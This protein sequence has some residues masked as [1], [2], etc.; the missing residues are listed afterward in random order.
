MFECSYC[1]KPFIKESAFLKHK[2]KTMERH[3]EIKTPIG[4]AAYSLYCTWMT[5]YKRN[6]PPIETFMVSRYYNGFIK[7]AEYVQQMNL[8]DVEGFIRLMIEKDLSP[9]LW[10]NDKVYVL[11]LENLDRRTNPIKQAE[12]SISTMIKLADILEIDVSKVFETVS[13]NDI[14]QLIRERRLSP[15]LLLFSSSFRYML[16]HR[17]TP[18]QRNLFEQLIRPMYWKVKFDRN[19]EYVDYMKSYVKEMGI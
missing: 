3:E 8:P 11:Y 19:P 16:A 9:F 13:P 14:L 1:H 18:E 4:Q 2:C 17:C 6:S 7:F 15:W 12:I 5:L 10:T